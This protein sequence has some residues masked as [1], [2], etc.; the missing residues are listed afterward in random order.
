MRFRSFV[1]TCALLLFGI[2]YTAPRDVSYAATS[3]PPSMG[4][5]IAALVATTATA[6]GFSVADPRVAETVAAIGRAAA[7][8]GASIA[9]GAG[10]AVGAVPWAAVAAAVA[11]G[12]VLG[13]VPV[14]LGKDTTEQ[15]LF[16][17]DGTVTLSA[18]SNVSGGS[19]APQ[20]PAL[21]SGLPFWCEGPYCGSSPEAALQANIQADN[22]GAPAGE[23]FAAGGCSVSGT[24]ATCSATMTLVSTDPSTGKQ[25][26]ST[27]TTTGISASLVGTYSGSPC[28]SGIVGLQGCEPYVPP[29]S[30]PPPPPVTESP[31]AGAA[32]VSAADQADTLNPQVLAAMTD[33]LWSQAATEQG[34]AG[35]PYPVN[36]PATTSQ[37]QGV[38]DQLGA[39]AP[40]VGS[41]VGGAGS[42]SGVSSTAPF[43]TSAPAASNPASAVPVATNPGSGAQVNLGPDPGIGAPSMEQ[44]PTARQILSPVLN[45]LPDLRSWVVPAHTGQCPEPTV[46]LF[47]QTFSFTTQCTFAEQ[48]RPQITGL[49]LM[50]F[51]IGSLFILLTA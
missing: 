13:S 38:E 43:S 44:T 41:V 31:T 40:T 26:A 6:N 22:A 48:Y 24:N 20:F 11:V 45:L 5:A 21:S 35:L 49:F 4:P 28:S 17:K 1:A 34:Y 37:A 33:A 15:W 47:G 19:V 50:A 42:L 2:V 30:T 18:G 10:V 7:V 46:D 8:A 32:G 25:T 39:A 23:S 51:A 27:N 14:T 29:P 9:V 12:V 16:N 36:A 3:A